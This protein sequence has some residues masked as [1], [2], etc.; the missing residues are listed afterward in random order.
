MLVRKAFADKK[1]LDKRFD[2][3]IMA[4]CV[5]H[6]SGMFKDE[7]AIIEVPDN[8]RKVWAMKDQF[9]NF[10][11]LLANREARKPNAIFEA[12][13]VATEEENKDDKTFSAYFKK[14]IQ[15]VISE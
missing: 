1:D 7:E 5:Q 14:T 4:G 11:P 15:T 2:T 9:M 6:F 13:F 10:A 12:F 3:N 8:V